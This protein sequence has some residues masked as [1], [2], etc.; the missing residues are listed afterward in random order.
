MVNVDKLLG[1][2]PHSSAITFLMRCSNGMVRGFELLRGGIALYLSCSAWF[3][4]VKSLPFNRLNFLS[5]PFLLLPFCCEENMDKAQ[6]M[7]DSCTS[8]SGALELL[9]LAQCCKHCT[10]LLIACFN[11]C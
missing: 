11:S 9:S 8:V 3:G 7:R 6:L 10:I 1:S 5:C 4:I 2:R